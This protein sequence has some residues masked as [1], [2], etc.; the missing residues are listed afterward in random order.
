MQPR[1]FGEGV[2]QR[3]CGQE[4]EGGR[5]I[6]GR[7]KRDK[8]DQEMQ[9]FPDDFPLKPREEGANTE[10]FTLKRSNDSLALL[11]AADH[12]LAFQCKIDTNQRIDRIPFI[13]LLGNHLIMRIRRHF[14]AGAILSTFVPRNNLFFI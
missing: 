9:G 4:T 2:K 1:A 13:C 14:L 3:A 11:H 7:E 6:D 8:G 5:K 12:C 10:W